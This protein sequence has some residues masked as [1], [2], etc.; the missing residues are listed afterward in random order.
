M[1]GIKAKETS[2]DFVKDCRRI[3]QNKRAMNTTLGS[4]LGFELSKT[5]REKCAACQHR[6][7]DKS[8]PLCFHHADITSNLHDFNRQV[9]NLEHALTEEVSRKTDS[10]V[11][12]F[13][14]V[15]TVEVE[16]QEV[17]I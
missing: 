13:P 10:K 7:E 4:L 5:H 11:R 12:A 3:F 15:R 9:R 14:N 1:L 17:P 16:V 6:E 8:Y 2:A